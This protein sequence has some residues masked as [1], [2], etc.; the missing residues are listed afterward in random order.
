M[1]AELVFFGKRLNMAQRQRRRMLVVLIYASLAILMAALWHFSHWRGT[2]AY[3]FWAAMLIC[4]LCL[5]GYYAG[6]LV[7]PFRGKAPMQSEM[8]PPLLLLKLRMYKPV[9]ADGDPAYRN[10]ERDLHQRDRAHYLAYQ[11]LGWAVLVPLF[12]ATFRLIKPALL[13]WIPMAPDEMYYGLLLIALTLFLTL[14]QA[15]MLWT[16]PDMESEA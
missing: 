15:I 3:V 16:E 10:D 12:L 1:N 13:D 7:K 8:P 11:G 2:G 14:P 5:G 4:R 6:G 9:L